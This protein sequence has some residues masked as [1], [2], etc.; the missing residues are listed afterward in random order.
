MMRIPKGPG[1]NAAEQAVL[2]PPLALPSTDLDV[3]VFLQYLQTSYLPYYILILLDRKE[4]L[5]LATP[6]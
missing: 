1:E 6:S 5:V 2:T 4:K 3:L